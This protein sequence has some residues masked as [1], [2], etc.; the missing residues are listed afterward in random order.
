MRIDEFNTHATDSRGHSIPMSFRWPEDM[1]HAVAKLVQSQ[2]FPAYDTSSSVVRDAIWHRLDELSKLTN[3][4]DNELA[5]LNMIK[6]ILDEEQYLASIASSI[7]RLAEQVNQ[8]KLHG[9]PEAELHA[10]ELIYRCLGQ[11]NQ[12]TGYWK[13]Y[14][15]KQLHERFGV[16]LEDDWKTEKKAVKDDD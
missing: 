2:Q 1:Q 10:T 15:L 12:L 13:K 8:L 5:R 3:V 11:A 9:T 16:M 4:I 7:S 14:I 6:E